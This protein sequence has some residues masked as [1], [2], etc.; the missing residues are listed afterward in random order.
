MMTLSY[1]LV[2]VS[3]NGRGDGKTKAA[4]TVKQKGPPK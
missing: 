4:G 3:D 2:F 1:G